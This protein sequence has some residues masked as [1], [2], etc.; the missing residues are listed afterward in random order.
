ML[1]SMHAFWLSLAGVE[2][3]EIHLADLAFPVAAEHHL[4]AHVADR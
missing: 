2:L 3:G 1:R 4:A